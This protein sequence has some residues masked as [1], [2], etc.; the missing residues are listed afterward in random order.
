MTAVETF[1]SQTLSV[2]NLRIAIPDPAEDIPIVRGISLSVRRGETVCVVGES[3]CGKSMTALALM[4]LLPRFVKC[5]SDEY[6]VNG[7]D[8]SRLSN[9]SMSGVRG[10]DIGMIFQ[11]P[12]TSLNPCLTIGSQLTEAFLRHGMGSKKDAADRATYLLDRTGI[13]NAPE[14]MRQYP[15]ELSGGLR[16]RVMIAM[17]LMCKPGFL[18]ADEPTTALDVTIQAQI[19]H[20]LKE[21][22]VENNIGMMFITHDL[23]VVANIADR[24]VV[25]YAGEVVEQGTAQD[26]IRRPAHPYTKALIDCLLVPGQTRPG[27]KLT[28]IPGLVPSGAKGNVCSFLNRC[29]YA[30][31][32]CRQPIML[33]E[34]GQKEH[35]YRCILDPQ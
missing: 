15:H 20:L 23:G 1:E 25:L 11:E 14:R 24:V 12:M 30:Q 33:R 7:K 22:Q 26:I 19:L 29:Y 28:T 8:L 9:R 27:Q 13:K 18:I 35:L 3:G 10:R 17:A 6:Q 32:A 34:S 2:K 21:L 4:S 5:A 31:N 16:Q